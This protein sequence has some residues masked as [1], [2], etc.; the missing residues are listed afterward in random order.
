MKKSQR[1]R[2]TDLRS[3]TVSFKDGRRRQGTQ[4]PSQSWRGE[5]NGTSP[6]SLQKEGSPNN[7]FFFSSFQIRD[8][9]NYKI[10]NLCCLQ[11]LQLW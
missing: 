6:W 10:T 3:I 11:P 5:R 8:L 2:E 9:P 7:I 4:V 1:S